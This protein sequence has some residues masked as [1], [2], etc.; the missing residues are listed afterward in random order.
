VVA[1]ADP[2]IGLEG[3]RI[4]TVLEVEDLFVESRIGGKRNTIVDGIR[5]RLGLGETIG[6]VGESGSGK[7]MT[8]RAITGLLPQ[9]LRANGRVTFEGRNVLTMTQSE[10]IKIRG[11]GISLLFQDPFTMLNPLMSAGAHIEETLAAGGARQMS[12]AERRMEVL[13]RLGE[14]G[15]TDSSVA[16]RYPFQ[17]SGGMRQR[18]GIA[19]A[20]AR[21][22]R[23]LIADEPSTALDVTTQKEILV[24]L[25]SLQTTRDMGLILITHNLRVALAMCDRIYVMYAGSV[26]EV[27]SAES[28]E[29][30]PLH[31][32]TLGLFLSEPPIK[33]RLRELATIP[34]SVPHADQVADMCSFAARCAWAAPSCLDGRTPLRVTDHN[35]ETACIR[36]EDIRGELDAARRLG[37]AGAP[38]VVVEALATEPLVTV[39]SVSKIFVTSQR[40]DPVAALNNVSIRVCQGEAVGIVGESGSGKTTLGR[41][42]VGLEQPT[43]GTIY[44]AGLDTTNVSR[45]PSAQRQHLRHTIQMIFQDPYSTLN[46]V[47]TVGQT[48][49]E[50]IRLGGS[51]R[52]ASELLE[53]V[54]LSASYAQRKPVAL[55]GG[56]RQRVSIARALAVD[57]QVLVLDEAVSALDVSVQAQMLTLFRSLQNE[58]GMTLIF[59]THDLAVARQIVDRLYVMYRG[60]I[61]EEG[62]VDRVL[63]NPEH[64]YTVRLV[65]SIPRSGRAWLRAAREEAWDM[66]GVVSG[67][68]SKGRLDS[69]SISLDA[70]RQGGGSRAIDQGHQRPS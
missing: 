21:D 22:C 18:V 38:D 7:T 2:R 40:G 42:L 11:S 9:G 25:K 62:A 1:H 4:R 54:G 29:S 8:V 30:E 63:D 37:E 53:R 60:V 68:K 20:L 13:R 49:A 5:L 44:I 28:I 52:Q 61:V 57:P 17:L 55:S 39:D 33:Q 3:H 59:I 10:L 50:A 41:C 56:E 46:P 26:L 16:D 6:I 24:L 48:L 12:R 15:I 69:T 43:S 67:D 14:V 47:H 27:A 51:R 65:R 34:G 36:L 23:V 58:L 64:P 31:P 35:R 45:M 32:Y 66:A 19:A 70:D